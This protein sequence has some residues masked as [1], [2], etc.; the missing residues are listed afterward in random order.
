MANN[1][2]RARMGRAGCEFGYNAFGNTGNISPAAVASSTTTYK[3]P[4]PRRR[5]YT[6]SASLQIGTLAAGSAGITIQLFKRNAVGAVNK[7]LTAVFD[8]KTGQVNNAQAVPITANENDRTLQDGDYYAWDIVA[9]GTIT[10]QPADVF[11]VIEAAI[12]E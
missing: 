2:Y 12:L 7:A 1:R 10:T 9:A 4:T 8:L 11:G 3:V 5:Q 6:E